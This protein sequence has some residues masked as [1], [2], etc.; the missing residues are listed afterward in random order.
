MTWTSKKLGFQHK[1]CKFLE[2][3]SD[4]RGKKWIS[5]KS[6]QSLI[7]HVNHLSKGVQAARLFMNRL[8]CMLRNTLHNSTRVSHELGKDLDWFEGFLAQ[9]NGRS[10]ILPPEPVAQIEADSCLIG[11]GARLGTYCYAVKYPREIAS[12][13]HISQ[14]EALNCLISAR[15]L[16]R[17]WKDVCIELICDNQG[18]T[19]CLASGKGRDPIILAISRAFWFISAKYNIRFWFSHMP[20]EMMTVADP[21]SRMFLSDADRIKAD[22]VIHQHGLRLVD[23]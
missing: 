22:D 20:G 19:S 8:L 11:G 1:I 6:L 12:S 4:I 2:L 5:Q 17:G 15:V 14:M 18:A 13:M 10:M 23:V 16:L 9:Y 7:G 21:L 3:I